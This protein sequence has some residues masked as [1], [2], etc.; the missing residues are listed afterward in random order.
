MRPKLHRRSKSIR[1]LAPPVLRALS[2]LAPAALAHAVA[3]PAQSVETPAPGAGIPGQSLARALE[4]FAN[5]TGLQLVYVS[6]VVRNRRSHAV[7]AGLD[8]VAT[9]TRLLQGT[10][11]T[12]QYLTPRSIRIVAASANPPALADSTVA[13]GMTL[14]QVIVT[15]NRREE[16]AHDVPMTRAGV[17]RDHA[18]AA[19]RHDLRRYRG[20][21]ARRHGA[22]R[23]A[24]PEQHLRAGPGHQHRGCAVIRRD[25]HFPECHACTWTNRPRSC[26]TAISTSTPRISSASRCWRVRKAR[27]SVP[28]PKRA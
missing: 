6:A 3:S 22:W 14:E 27:C 11:L 5:Q 2:M 10:N 9:L 26:R 18:G 21:P 23:G 25:R 16:Y 1:S 7:P 24:Q 4:I 8:A 13:A 28:A 15:A 17:D 12:F 19:E 20:L